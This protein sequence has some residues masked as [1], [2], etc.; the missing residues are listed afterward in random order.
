MHIIALEL[1]KYQSKNF[2]IILI[3]ACV[4]KPYSDR[5]G[6]KFTNGPVRLPRMAR[7]GQ[8]GAGHRWF[9]RKMIIAHSIPT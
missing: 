4:G 3:T 9:A 6:A 2:Q 7:R 1:Q 8:G 5:R